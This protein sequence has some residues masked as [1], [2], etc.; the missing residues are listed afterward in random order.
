MT[1]SLDSTHTQEVNDVYGNEYFYYSCG[2]SFQPMLLPVDNREIGAIAYS[3]L[4]STII[5]SA[6]GSGPDP[7]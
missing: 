1:E 5:L 4:S 3:L 7:G 2:S 6:G